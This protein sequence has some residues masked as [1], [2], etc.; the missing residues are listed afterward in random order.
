ML[1]S[2]I[3]ARMVGAIALAL[4]VGALG[5]QYLGHI[6]PCKMCH[7]QRWALIAAA[8]TGL[9]GIP[10]WKK[11]AHS[12]AMTAILFVTISGLIAAYQTGMQFGILPDLKVCAIERL[13]VFFGPLITANCMAIDWTMFGLTLAAYNAIISLSVAA[14]G[15]VLL[16]KN[17]G[18]D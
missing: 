10:L 18:S 7:W 2:D 13:F 15:A 3:I 1:R 5:I 11:G 14:I 12:L 4:I 6:Q 9:I 8:V 16:K 17:C